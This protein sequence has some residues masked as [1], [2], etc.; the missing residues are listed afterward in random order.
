[1][2]PNTTELI[3]ICHI[4]ERSQWVTE[5]NLMQ[6]I[7]NE[8]AFAFILTD[9]SSRITGTLRCDLRERRGLTKTLPPTRKHENRNFVD[10]DCSGNCRFDGPHSAASAWFPPSDGSLSPFLQANVHVLILM[11]DFPAS[12]CSVGN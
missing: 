7:I 5:N 1:M 11:A 2:P 4:C 12:P 10:P 6:L 8:V 3:H 9:L